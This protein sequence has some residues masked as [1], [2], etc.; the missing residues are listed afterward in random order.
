MEVL[1]HLLLIVSLTFSSS[2]LTPQ[3]VN[4]LLHLLRLFE[5]QITAPLLAAWKKRAH[6]FMTRP[7]FKLTTT[8]FEQLKILRGL[9]HAGTATRKK[10][11]TK[12]NAV[13]Q[14]I[15]MGS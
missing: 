3:T 4:H 15:F 10:W 14:Y 13:E 8:F 6:I 1:L 7:V 5:R 11:L 12:W 9:S 2:E